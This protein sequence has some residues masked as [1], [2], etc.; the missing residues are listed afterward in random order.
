MRPWL[1]AAL[2][3]LAAA[4]AARGGVTGSI[5]LRGHAAQGGG[6]FGMPDERALDEL[7]QINAAGFPLGEETMLL[8]GSLN[9]IRSDTFGLR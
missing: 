5:T 2:A 8:N 4:T 1:P 6:R 7:L 3:L 9:L